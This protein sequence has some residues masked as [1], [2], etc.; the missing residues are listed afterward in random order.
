ML[1]NFNDELHETRI[2]IHRIKQLKPFEWVRLGRQN[3]WSEYNE[4]V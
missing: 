2:F 3:K 4:K 1:T